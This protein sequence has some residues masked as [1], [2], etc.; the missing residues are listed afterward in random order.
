VGTITSPPTVLRERA[1]RAVN[2]LP[3]FSPILSKLLATLAKDDV[4]FAELSTIIEKDTVLAGYVLRLVNS[5]LYA[6]SGTINSVRHAVSILGLNKLR[7]VALSL[8]VS[9]MWQQVKTPKS[10]S[11]A[12]FNVHSVATAV[13]ADSLAQRVSVR[14]PEGAFTAGL[15]H[16]VGKLMIAIGVPEQHEIILRAYQDSTSLT[17]EEAEMEVIGCCNTDLAASALQQWKLPLEIQEAVRD[18]NRQLR[19]STGSLGLGFLMGESHRMVNQLGVMIPA[20]ACQAE[21]TAEAML[22]GLGLQTQAV[23]ILDEYKVEFET[24]RGFF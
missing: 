19:G 9:R 20:C 11:Q 8:S 23:A 6:R 1:Q 2:Q 24:M 17:M 7:N 12:A 21:S 18:Q 14:Y 22:A 10:W 3:P 4:F 5:A 13:M 15:L 16:A